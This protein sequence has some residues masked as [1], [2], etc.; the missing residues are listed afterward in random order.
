LEFLNIIHVYDEQKYRHLGMGRSK[1]FK[2]LN[3]LTIVFR[4]VK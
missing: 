3:I 2:I 4:L 1:M